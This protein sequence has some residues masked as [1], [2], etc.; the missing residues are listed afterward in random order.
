MKELIPVLLSH[1][2]DIP[3]F[4]E[5]DFFDKDIAR[6]LGLVYEQYKKTNKI[7]SLDLAKSVF[8]INT[9]ETNEADLEYAYQQLEQWNV[10]QFLNKAVDK[11]ETS[12]QEIETLQNKYKKTYGDKTKSSTSFSSYEDIDKI[13]KDFQQTTID[14]IS[15][16]YPSFDTMLNEQKGWMRKGLYSVMG[17]S[18]YGKSIFL[19]NFA[20][21]SFQNNQKVLYISTEMTEPEINERFFKSLTNKTT[22]Q[23]AFLHI[24]K[25]KLKY[26]GSFQVIKIDPYDATVNDIQ[27]IIDKVEVKPDILYIDYADELLPDV[28]VNSEYDAQGN[29]YSRLKKLANENNIPVITATQTNRTAEAENG[30]TKTYVG[31]GAIADSSKKIRLVDGLFSIIQQNGDREENKI[32]LQIVKNRKSKSGEMLEFNIDYS[33]MRINESGIV[34]L[35]DI[36][37]KNRDSK[38]QEKKSTL[39][40]MTTP[41]EFDERLKDKRGK[42]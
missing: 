40:M 12:W 34:P 37:K 20:R 15:T 41:Q 4:I 36:I 2:N 5:N 32:Y 16:G 35:K 7:I 33:T 3:P 29:V 19:T 17:L 10:L 14:T 11:Q 18:G 8:D 31:F 25:Y 28:K 39:N 27:N 38:I 42:I 26:E 1:P 30:G 9:L 22:F 21:S 13:Y 24:Q 6:K 23:E